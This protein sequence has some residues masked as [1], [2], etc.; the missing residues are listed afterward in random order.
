M[1]PDMSTD[2]V[3]PTAND[4]SP[5]II[6]GAPVGAFCAHTGSGQANSSATAS[7]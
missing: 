1:I 3:R 4:S 6:T 2:S 7:N 5:A